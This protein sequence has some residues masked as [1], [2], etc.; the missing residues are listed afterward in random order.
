MAE[1]QEIK[2]YLD[3]GGLGIFW[4]KLKTQHIDVLSKA[5]ND[6]VARATEAEAALDKAYKAADTALESAYKA[7]DSA[8]ESAYKAA[9]SALE[10][11]LQAN[12]DKK[13]ATE[14]YEAGIAALE[15]AYKAADSALESKLQANID[16]KVETSDYNAKVTALE[17]AD[18][19]MGGRI[20]DLEEAVSNMA[21]DSTVTE[22]QSK[23]NTLIGDD[24]SMSA[25]AI[26]QDEVAKQ[27]ESENISDSFDTLK[28][29][30][31]YLSSHP[32]TV[33]EINAGI[34]K[35]SDDIAG[36]IDRATK[37]EAALDAAYK[38]ADSKLS[39]ELTAAYEAADTALKN[40]L[41]GT[42]S[43][44]DTAY[45]A[46]DADLTTAIGTKVAQSDYNAKVT[47]LEGADSA[48]DARITALENDSTDSEA[49]ANEATARANQDDKI[50]ASVGLDASGNYVKTTGKYSSSASTVVAAIAAVEA[51][52]AL[53]E[54]AIATEKG[55]AEG[56]EAKIRADFAAADAQI[57]TDFAAVDTAIR[58][59]IANEV[60]DLEDAIA[61]KADQSALEAEATTRGN[62]ISALDTAY[63]AA[64]AELSGRISAVEATLTTDYVTEDEWKNRA[65]SEAEIIALFA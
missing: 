62:A 48:M 49:I 58:G 26:V 11:K 35:N 64:D 52:V 44:M 59:E 60:K 46:A 36:E 18:T 21:S 12:I 51:Q 33:T 5:I 39:G 47:A 17:G 15:G 14:T 16:K 42:I 4:T 20:S 13:V 34:K 23:L 53:N 24:A 43:A 65:I 40:E 6:E 38:A 9:D 56:E 3:L 37:A 45:K 1:T 25:R 50:E 7:A 10:S 30:A 2:K 8:L 61:L 32:N 57:R 31:E 63:K 28:E 41:S 19:A 22:I 54:T 29:M 27:L 55:R